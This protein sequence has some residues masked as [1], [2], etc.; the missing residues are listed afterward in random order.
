[1]IS[2]CRALRRASSRCWALALPKCRCKFS[3]RAVAAVL[4]AIAITIGITFAGII[5][6][7]A[8]D[9]GRYADS[10]LRDWFNGLSSG[11]GLCCSFADGVTVEEPDW[12]TQGGLYLVRVCRKQPQPPE[13]WTSCA[14]KVWLPVPDRALVK[15]PNRYGPAVVWPEL[16]ADHQTRIRCFLPGSGV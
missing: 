12:Q 1:V 7:A 3:P 11:I 5:A 16:N 8:R 10:P 15:E 9:D 4:H 6:V 13:T 2:I 14:D